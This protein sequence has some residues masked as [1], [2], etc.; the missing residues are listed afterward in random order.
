MTV[1]YTDHKMQQV[2]KWLI[3]LQKNENATCWLDFCLLG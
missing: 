1:L 3:V 2:V